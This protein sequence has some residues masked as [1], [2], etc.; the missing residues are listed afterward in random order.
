[1][2]MDIWNVR[3]C[4]L[5]I[6]WGS[7]RAPDLYGCI[8]INIWRRM[9][10]QAHTSSV[11]RKKWDGTRISRITRIGTDNKISVCI[12]QI[13]VIRVLFQ[14]RI[15][16]HNYLSH[17]EKRYAL[18]QSNTLTD[19]QWD[20]AQRAPSGIHYVR[21]ICVDQ[22]LK[23]VPEVLIIHLRSSAFICGSTFL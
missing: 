14:L 4:S 5:M 10:D 20:Q 13:C 3:I 11:K 8:L 17:F 1:M 21:K 16:N 7:Y 23:N 22:C 15:G 2:W 12:R 18:N 6:A 9:E 19:D